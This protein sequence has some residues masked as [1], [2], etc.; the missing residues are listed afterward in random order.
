[1]ARTRSAST[2][3]VLRLFLYSIYISL[4]LIAGTGR[5]K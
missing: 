2:I 3:G 5:E 4:I 1:M